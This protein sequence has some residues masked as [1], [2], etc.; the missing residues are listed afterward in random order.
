[1]LAP[2]FYGY[3]TGVFSSRQLEKA[4]YDSIAFRFICA[5]QHPD[6][7]SINAFRKRFRTE[8][9]ALF[10]QVLQIAQKAGW[11]KLGNVSLDG[12]KSL[13]SEG[14]GSRCFI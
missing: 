8:I 7:D 10:V 11:L 4:S 2:L 1:M 6:H 12:T 14:V 13:H 9:S 3:A 5:N